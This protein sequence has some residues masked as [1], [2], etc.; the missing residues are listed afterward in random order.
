M[1]YRP[2][3]LPDQITLKYGP[4]DILERFFGMADAKAA[5]LG[6]AVSVRA[7]FDP[8][9]ALHKR[10][11]QEWG[12][13]PASLDPRHSN[14]RID[15]AFW[16]EGLDA[17]GETAF[18]HAARLFEWENTNLG[19]EVRSLRAFYDDPAKPLASGVRFPLTG[20]AANRIKGRCVFLGGLWVRPDCRG[21]GL[22]HL[23]PRLTSAYA[24]TRWGFDYA[25][26]IVETHLYEAGLTGNYGPY[27]TEGPFTAETGGADKIDIVLLW[28][29]GPAIVADLAVA[30]DPETKPSG[31]KIEL[32]HHGETQN[33]HAAIGAAPR[34]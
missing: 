28:A 14:L 3:R 12:P 34:Q 20:A 13:L 1:F 17:K 24:Y 19:E 25:W 11:R 15:Q 6:L 7:E 16:I 18:V 30:I 26:G 29:G 2:R 9:L 8:L 31:R 33:Q 4:H 23:V 21:R 27:R 22:S 5:E 10:H 32:P